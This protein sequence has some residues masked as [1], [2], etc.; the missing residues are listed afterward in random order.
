MAAP[1]QE[2]S[3]LGEL[4]SPVANTLPVTLGV[5]A[6]VLSYIDTSR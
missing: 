3:S 4:A 6:R 2:R 1:P 5:Q